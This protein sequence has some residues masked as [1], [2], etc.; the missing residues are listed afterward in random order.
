[1]AVNGLTTGVVA[2]GAGDENSVALKA[3]GSVWAWGRNDRGQLGNGTNTDSD[4]PV[5][6]SGLSS[7]VTAIADGRDFSL[8][9]KSDGSVWGWGNNF[10]SQLGNGTE[11]TQEST[12]TRV[13]G[14]GARVTAI[15]VGDVHSMALTS[16]ARVWAWGSNRSGQLGDGSSRD[17]RMPVQVS[18]LS[19]VK[20]IAAGR[21][22]DSLA[23]M[24]DGSVWAWGWGAAG[25][26]GNGTTTDRSV[27]IAVSS[28]ARDV[29]AI[30]AGDFD[31]LALKSDG[32]VWAWG[33]NNHGELGDGVTQPEGGSNTPVAVI[34]LTS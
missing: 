31:N 26:L 28:L 19:G 7:G 20:A 14:L 22:D 16:E 10:N 18:I 30:A 6:V 4:V 8:A 34:G 9:L 3:D 1:V 29:T 27:P 32:S 24:S 15:A 5:L 11:E 13:K 12:P 23:L 33:S 2:I 25:Q 21:S 17:S